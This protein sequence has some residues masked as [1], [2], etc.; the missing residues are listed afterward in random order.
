MRSIIK[1]SGKQIKLPALL[2][3][4][5][6]LGGCEKALDL[7][8][9]K[10]NPV[11]VFEEAWKVMDEQYALFSV[12]GIDWK[13]TYQTYRVQ[14]TEE[15]TDAALFTVIDHMLETLK[16]GHVSLMSA[17]DTATYDG[18]FTLYSTN[19][20]YK[21]IVTSYLKNDFK[22][23][24]PVIYK[25]VNNVG[26]IYY[27]SFKNDITESEADQVMNEMSSTKGI[28]FDVRNNTGG[29]SANAE[30]FVRRFLG[31]KTLVKYEQ[32]KNG[33]GHENFSDAAPYFLSGNSTPY[34]KPVCVL[35][36]RASFSACNDFV[37]FMSVL[38]NVKVVGD[39]TG[40]GGG[41]P[42][43]YVLLNGWKLQYTAT[44][45]LDINKH[46]VENGITPDVNIGIT[47][48]EES[49]GKDPILEKAYALLQ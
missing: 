5:F 42:N 26:Y 25:T 16:D 35:T 30:K 39:Q 34:T 10:S 19:F 12:K 47:L 17:S 22:V 2:L 1:E 14:V 33:S 15:M 38:P 48:L 41:F 28:I 11:L 46:P 7:K 43:D 37:L 21:N 32:I 13:S 44:K 9:V 36:N 27:A 20:N 4:L 23:S 6:F 8:P 29:R 18:F 40:G 49:G 45:T 24:G 31:E 3:V